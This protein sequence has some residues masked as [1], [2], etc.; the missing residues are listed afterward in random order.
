[1]TTV[2]GCL[3][4]LSRRL[5]PVSD[6]P[7]LDAQVL[8]AR[9][10]NRPRSWLAAHP[11]TQL[12]PEPAAALEASVQRLERGEPLPYVLGEWEFF[13]L[14]FDLTPDVLIPRPETELLVERA[15]SWLR[16]R[17]TINR[18]VTLTK[19]AEADSLPRVLDVGTGCGCIAISLAVNVP[20]IRVVAT[21][22]SPAALEVAQRN[23][24]KL[25]VADRITFLEA[26][27]IPD[28]FPPD[29]FS[30]IVAN[31]PY[32][33]TKTLHTLPIYT[34][35]PTLALDGGADGLALIRR[36][37]EKAPGALA[38]GGLMLLEIEA[39]EGPAVLSLAYDV[40]ER[41]DIHQHQDLAGH[42]RLLEIQI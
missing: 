13:S 42:D 36:L 8:L 30:L 25:N 3:E 17:L 5:H 15:I 16:H 22:I 32:I 6:T 20:E 26:D 9:T 33:P 38:P 19:S 1:M 37:L 7:D 35:E 29:P 4:E 10:M 24:V 28:A 21:D 40:F 27:L 39:S 11:E 2:S 41:A 34:R 31:L 12:D 23:A 14:P 18:Q